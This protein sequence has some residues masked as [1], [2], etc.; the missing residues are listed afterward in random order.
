MRKV[1]FLIGLAA[2]LGAGAADKVYWASTKSVVYANGDEAAL[3][4][5]GYEPLKADYYVDRVMLFDIEVVEA[6]PTGQAGSRLYVTPVWADGR[7][8]GSYVETRDLP[9]K[10]GEKR[11]L[12]VGIHVYGDP[13]ADIRVVS[14]W[15]TSAKNAGGK[16]KLSNFRIL[17]GDVHPDL[18]KY[19]NHGYL[20]WDGKGKTDEHAYTGEYL[21]G[22]KTYARMGSVPFTPR[23]WGN[24]FYESDPLMVI[25]VNKGKKQTITLEEDATA[26]ETTD[27]DGLDEMMASDDKTA[28]EQK[29]DLTIE[30]KKADPMRWLYL[31]HSLVGGKKGF[32]MKIRLTD[33]N[34]KTAEIP[35]RFG[36]DTKDWLDV[37]DREN[38]HNEVVYAVGMPRGGC[39]GYDETGRA[40]AATAIASR[41]AIPKELAGIRKIEFVSG[42]GKDQGLMMIHDLLLTNRGYT[43]NTTDPVV[44][45]KGKVWHETAWPVQPGIK[46]GS[47]MDRSPKERHTID[48]LGR[49]VNDGRG[50]F[51]CEKDPTR[52]PVRFC[53]GPVLEPPDTAPDIEARH[54]YIENFV[55]TCYR[56]GYRVLDWYGDA[57]WGYLI[58]KAGLDFDEKCEDI[59]FYA[60]K[61]MEDR[62]MYLTWNVGPGFYEGPPW[63][64]EYHCEK[65]K[66]AGAWIWQTDENGQE[67]R[68]NMKAGYRRLFTKVNPYT[69]RRLV[70]SPVL[71]GIVCTGENIFFKSNKWHKPYIRKLLEKKYGEIDAI[72]EAWNGKKNEYGKKKLGF[73]EMWEKFDD[74]EIEGKWMEEDSPRGRDLVEIVMAV[75]RDTIDFHRNFLRELGYKGPINDCHI[76]HDYM[77]LLGRYKSE[78][79]SYNSYH[80]HPLPDKEPYR[81]HKIWQDSS[82]AQSLNYYRGFCSGRLWHKPSCVTE[83]DMPFFCVYRYEQP[84]MQD[85]YLALGGF[86]IEKCFSLGGIADY[87]EGKDHGR[88]A[89]GNFDGLHD[90]VKWA[91]AYLGYYI[92]AERCVKTSELAFRV[93]VTEK[94]I[95]D[96][97]LF[98]KGAGPQTQLALLGRFSM[99]IVRNGEKLL[100]PDEKEVPMPRIGGSTFYGDDSNGDTKFV[101]MKDDL[102]T[103]FEVQPIVEKLKKEGLL[104]ADNRTDVSKQVWESSTGELYFDAFHNFGTID[105]PRLQLFTGFKG[106]T[107][108]LKN[109]KVTKWGERGVLGFVARDGKPLEES[110]DIMLVY[111]TDAMNRGMIFTEPSMGYCVSMGRGLPLTKVGSFAC[112]IRNKNASKLAMRAIRPDGNEMAYDMSKY[113]RAD[114]DR[115]IV[116]MDTSDF[117]EITPFFHLSDKY[118]K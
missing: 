41:F 37:K 46:Q 101:S 80:S 21:G 117:D 61:C 109:L 22:R 66:M 96:N 23:F 19:M 82:I 1:L 102:S 6:P 47:P 116:E 57:T 30:V 115:L 89:L 110:S 87:V 76:V 26:N 4:G 53:S 65:R 78:Y 77:R 51:V 97:K 24:K 85:A 112:E 9:V 13:Y 38:A 39:Q 118:A 90:S 11:E 111:S 64:P 18:G 83:G 69:K 33:D 94:E 70:D 103:K 79:T 73:D 56:A 12:S 108:A 48:E 54:A 104:P 44:I 31:M 42:S 62:G 107:W 59:L 15:P 32:K 36:I 98:L 27:D 71:A 67:A 114:G 49:L 2:A 95:F 100:P 8:F 93:D 35:I 86:C 7:A 81:N 14:M 10:V 74:I 58:E 43:M 63:N 3:L 75:H 34:G 20:E 29:A 88:L 92:F 52:T 105:T 91:S 28:D 72:K 16:W 99:N 50:F 40:R 55:E 60:E 45:A 84:F 5:E 68:E 106:N 17:D 25:C 113:V